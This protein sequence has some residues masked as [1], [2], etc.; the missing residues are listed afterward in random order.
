M[1]RNWPIYNTQPGWVLGF[2]GCDEAV[3]KQVL[4]SDSLG[5]KKSEQDHDWLGS[6]VY[7]W[8]GSPA[9]AW[10]WAQKRSAAGR[11][12]TP[13]V[14]G[15]IID[16]KVCLDLFQQENL[17]LLAEVHSAFAHMQV[18]EGLDMPVNS[19]GTDD[20]AL[21]RLDCAVIEM[22]HR[23][24]KAQVKFDPSISEFDSVR[25]PFYESGELYEGAG[26]SAKN[27]IQI[28]IRNPACI[29]GYFLPRVV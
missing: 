1:S 12:K 6:G 24:R 21:R 19:G 20:K 2:H 8:Q 10:E 16:L 29:K 23:I 15:A 18:K 13:F 27:H 9:R 5:L 4:N 14:I 17:D 3:G 11:I 22:A 26:I 7:F 28:A 25:S